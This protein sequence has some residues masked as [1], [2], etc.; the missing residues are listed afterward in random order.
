MPLLEAIG[1]CLRTFSTEPGGKLLNEYIVW[2]PNVYGGSWEVHL[3]ILKLQRLE[4]LQE[5]KEIQSCF[6]SLCC[7]VSWVSNVP[8]A[9]CRSGNESPEKGFQTSSISRTLWSFS[10]V[11]QLSPPAKLLWGPRDFCLNLIVTSWWIGGK[12]HHDLFYVSS[13]WFAKP[14][15]NNQNTQGKILCHLIWKCWDFWINRPRISVAQ[16]LESLYPSKM[17]SFEWSEFRTGAEAVGR[18]QS[19]SW[20]FICLFDFPL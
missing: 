14:Y 2:F 18:H 9:S 5:S 17:G 4:T 16:K 20:L 3:I 10:L 13:S 19:S 15:F 7:E 12:K 6:K 1:C 11:Q 8:N